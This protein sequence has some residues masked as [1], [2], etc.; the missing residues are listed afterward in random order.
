M[1]L[2]VPSL[3]LLLLSAAA[4]ARA[5]APV[6][7]T[8]FPA[9]RLIP[10]KT[11]EG[12]IDVESA[13]IAEAGALDAAL[14]LHYARNPLVLYERESGDLARRGALVRDR[15]EGNLVL[16][17][18][19][20][21]WAEIGVDLPLI[22]HQSRPAQAEF[23]FDQV[24]LPALATSGIG[25]VSVQPKLRPLRADQ[26]GFDVAVLASISFP[27][28]GGNAYRGEEAVTVAPALALSRE[29]NTGFRIGANVGYLVRP[30]AAFLG[31]VIDDQLFYRLG[32][33]HRFDALGG[34]P[35]GVGIAL[36]G[37]FSAK[38]PFDTAL[39]SPLELLGQVE[40]DLLSSL[41]LFGGGGLSIGKGFG[42]PDGR[43]F[44]GARFAPRARDRDG[45]GLPDRED[46][47]PDRA[48]D[49]D[50]FEDQDGC[51]DLDNDSDKIPDARDGAPNDPEDYDNFKDEDGV[52]DP[53]NDED[54]LVDPE[55]QCPNE[56]G[57]LENKGCPDCDHDGLVDASDDCPTEPEDLDSYQDQD[58]CPDPDNDGDGL[59]DGSDQCPS[60][61]GPAENR[62]CPDTDRDGDGVADR[63][64]NCPDEPGSADNRGCK[65]PQLVQITSDRLIIEERVFF[66]TGSATILARSYRLLQ[67]VAQVII[68]HPEIPRVIVEGHTDDV[69]SD[70]TNKKLSQRRAE[71][72]RAY[73]IRQRVS[74][75]RLRAI[76]YGEERPIAPNDTNEGRS[77]NRRVEFVVPPGSAVIE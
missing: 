12:I 56:A 38:N 30:R 68:A 66:A 52:P 23:A 28:S 17:Y 50:G 63:I 26:I 76:G 22:F 54:Q 70:E 60:K 55:D 51:P 21:R 19:P 67:N 31:T 8:A 24:S 64:D 42:A 46:R 73:L 77:T 34:P 62:G 33:G 41:Q 1:K 75:D 32:Y 43:A 27:S 5:Q 69:G 39:E 20:V 16:A 53:D 15:F 65:R 25:D 13:G 6:E 18:A 11:V 59:A 74:A 40:Y 10:A 72:V 49:P 36:S 61:A 37:S 7:V 58:G 29:F 14:W 9:E 71:S 2:R 35:L 48:E 45:D 47:C 3:C 57:S 4:S 44:L